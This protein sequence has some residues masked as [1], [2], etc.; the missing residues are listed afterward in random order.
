MRSLRSHNC[1][2]FGLL[3]VVP[4]ERLLGRW[5]SSLALYETRGLPEGLSHASRRPVRPLVFFIETPGDCKEASV[6]FRSGLF[7]PL[8]PI[9]EPTRLLITAYPR[10]RLQ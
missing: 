10:F 6:V 3:A 2:S 1:V 8:I 4:R 7:L 9:S 5:Y